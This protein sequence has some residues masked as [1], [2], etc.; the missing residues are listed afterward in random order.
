[1][2]MAFS[3]ASAPPLVKNTLWNPD[4]AR[5][6]MRFA[7]SPRARL[8]VDGAM[9]VS[10]SA[11]S[12]IACTTAGCWCP[13]LT[14][15]SWLEK[16]RYS[17]PEWSHTREPRPLAIVSVEACDCA[18]QE[19]KTWSLS[20]SRASSSRPSV[21]LSVMASLPFCQFSADR[22]APRPGAARIEI[23]E[24]VSI[25]APSSGATR[26]PEFG[27]SCRPRRVRPRRARSPR[28]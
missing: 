23:C 12:R 27:S 28:P 14:F 13:M 25:R 7:A 10:S 24:R 21:R 20:S 15:T 4:G 19:W 16:S 17:R 3:L 26:P 1:M 8:T 2:R 9:V 6:T 22:V 5:E 18:D 11:C